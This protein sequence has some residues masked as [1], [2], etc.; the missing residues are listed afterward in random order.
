MKGLVILAIFLAIG[1]TAY[2]IV[3]FK[4]KKWK[5]SE[6]GC[7]KVMGGDFAS[8]EKCKQQCAVKQSY[9]STHQRK[10]EE[11]RRGRQQKKV[12]WNPDLVEYSPE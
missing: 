1:V 5:C 8:L 6:K 11:G 7:E 12:N 2:L 4:L 9:K 10:L 3:E